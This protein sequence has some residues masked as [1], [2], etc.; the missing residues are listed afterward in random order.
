VA[1]MY[2]GPEF[3][4][5]LS[6]VAV[7]EECSFGR[8]AERI[9]LAQ[10]S[11]SSQIKQVEDGLGANLFIRSQSGAS[12]TAPGRQFL[13]FARQMLQM[14]DHAVRVTTSDKSGT[15]LLQSLV[16]RVKMGLN[17]GGAGHVRV[18]VASF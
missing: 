1:I 18:Q 8:A 14:R 15:A 11:L 16:V 3:R 10:P 13:I 9:N 17:G 2:E 6:F 12:L 5:L 4:H 7:A